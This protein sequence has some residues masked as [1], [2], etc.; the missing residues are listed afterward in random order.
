MSRLFVCILRQALSGSGMEVNM[1]TVK[2]IVLWLVSVFLLL[3]AAVLFTESIH[4]GL[5]MFA[6]AMLCNPLVLKLIARGGKKIKPYFSVPAV[7]VLFFTAI[8]TS[9]LETQQDKEQTSGQTTDV[10]ETAGQTTDV[11]ET[12]GQTESDSVLL[13]EQE[14]IPEE[15]RVSSEAENG[16]A[17]DDWKPEAAELTVHYLDVGQGD[18]MLLVCDGEYMLIDAG[19]NSKG[20]AVQNYLTKQGVETLKYVIGTHPDADHVGGLDVVLYKFDCETVI[21]PDVS[22]DT[23]TYRDVLDTM[24]QKGYKSTLPAAGQEFMLGSAVCTILGPRTSYEDAN[25][26]SV[27]LLVTHGTNRFLFM[28]DAE[29]EAEDDIIRGG[30]DVK[31]DVIKVGHHGSRYSSS[32]S[33][34]DAVA[35]SYAVISCGEDNSYGHPHADTLNKL[36]SMG[37]EVF[38]NDEQGTVTAVSDGSGITWNSAPSQSWKAGEPTGGSHTEEGDRSQS[39]QPDRE[40][41]SGQSSDAGDSA[42][43]DENVQTGNTT[44]NDAGDSAGV[45]R[46]DAAVSTQGSVQGTDNPQEQPQEEGGDAEAVQL[47]QEAAQTGNYIGNKNNDR[48]HKAACSYLPDEKNRAYFNTREEAVAAGYDIPCKKCN[49]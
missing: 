13:A 4:G 32:Q 22:K 3:M 11:M 19:D 41:S 26:N 40:S 37:V 42:Q 43:T 38:R 47:P 23:K 7:V 35:P 10:M 18:C 24:D 28:G 36:R 15:K 1:K 33:F 39:G 29:A 49:P 27:V 2:N 44:G 17:A 16:D 5:L 45:D 6:A 9:P 8:L 20:T 34:L 25:N 31:A 21:L 12:E 48:L 14:E 30:A 46:A